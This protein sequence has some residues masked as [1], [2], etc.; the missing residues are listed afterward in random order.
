MTRAILTLNSV[1]VITVAV[2]GFF[3]S[4]LWHSPLLF[5]KPWMA[6][7]KLSEADMRAAAEKGMAKFFILGFLFTLLSTFGLAAFL[8]A[9]RPTWWGGGALVGG[10]F[11]LCIVGARFLNSG[12]WEQRSWKLMAIGVGHE[13]TLFAVQG[14]ILAVWR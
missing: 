13:V 3:L 8:N 6:E 7:M 10:F 11:G 4:W 2:I 12:V 9:H 14:T 5:A 1:E